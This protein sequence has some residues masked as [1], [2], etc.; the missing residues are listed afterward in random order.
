[1][2]DLAQYQ[3]V[4]GTA[5]E[6]ASSVEASIREGLLDTGDRLPTVRALSAQLG[7]SPATV[8]A[9][10]RIL[11]QRGF[12][13][14]EGRRGTRV[15]PR[16][17]LRV[18]EL[19]H[20][21][22]EAAENGLR[23]LTIGLPD[24]S[25]LPPVGPALAR[26]DVE[27]KLR[28]A[29]FEAPDPELLELAAARFD[30]D[31]LPADQIAVT[32]GAFDA[33]ERVLQAHLRPGDRVIVEDPTYPSIRDLLMALGLIE[34]PVGVDER[35]LQPEPF[36]DALAKGVQGLVLVPRAQNPLGA[37]M[38]AE[39]ADTLKQLLEPHPGVLVVE[40]DHAGLVAGSPFSTLVTADRPRWAVIRSTSKVLNPALRLAVLA[41]DET[42]ICRVE[43]RQ[44]LGP[45]WV[46]HLLQALVVEMLRDPRFERTAIHARD[47]Y[48]ARRNALISELAEREVPAHG[49]SGMN[50]WVPVREEAPVVRA[51]HE[52]GLLVMAGERFRI[53]TPPGIRITTARLRDGEAAEIARVIAAVEHAGPARRAY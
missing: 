47:V 12:V 37:A 4:G 25:L 46:S 24:A 5:R 21:T 19:S 10:Y 13:I 2:L 43:G 8:N 27:R 1:M 40:D 53:T 16:P 50:V 17:A 11:R 44:A 14:T 34:V 20:T 23:D 7:I 39:R 52:A 18:P 3:I 6:I 36:A 29:A 15:A 33:I 28:F 22:L 41:G 30:A 42:T 48:A 45:R 9:A 35:G 31:G 38:D 26:V 32:S 49:R 51:L